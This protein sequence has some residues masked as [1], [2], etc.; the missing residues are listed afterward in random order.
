M[1]RVAILIHGGY[2][3]RVLRDEF[4]GAK[5]HFGAFSRAI[6]GH[7]HLDVDILR[8]YYYHCLPYKS[9]PPTREESNRFS[10]KQK[11]YNT[12]NRLPRFEVKLGW[13]ARRGLDKRGRYLFEQKMVD[14]LTSIDMVHLSA[15]GQ[16]GDIAIVAR[17]SDFVPAVRMAKWEGVLVRLFHGRNPH[18]QLWDIVDERVRITQELID[19]IPLNSR[20]DKNWNPG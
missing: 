6:S 7:M 16:V 3:D 17:D 2:V 15:K 5:I 20:V 13:L 1:N 9:D 8:T 4:G 11:F 12:I 18:N 10:K 14:V 19:K